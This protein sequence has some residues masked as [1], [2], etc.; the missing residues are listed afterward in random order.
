VEERA[1]ALTAPSGA[2]TRRK[3][4]AFVALVGGAVAMGA[5]PIFV[6][7]ADV[8]PYASAFWRTAL[9][10]PFLWAWARWEA[11]TVPAGAAPFDRAVL[12]SGLFFAGDLFFWHLSILSTTVAN[13]TFLATTSP[14]WVAL[15]AWL[16]FGE[17]IAGATGAGLA[18]CLLGGAA[19]V[20]QSYSFAPE[21]LWGD[22][23]GLITAVFFGSYLLAI[24]AGRVR[25][26]AAGLMFRSTLVTTVCLLVIALLF[27]D[28]VLPRSAG[29]AAALLA[30][31]LVSQVGGQGLLAVALGTLPAT[32]SSL[33]IF[34]EAIAAALFGW[35]ILHE[36]LGPLQWLGGLLILVGIW[37]GRP[38]AARPSLPEV[39][40]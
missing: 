6:R 30:L 9:A 34:I 15:A 12:L 7:L 32:F 40:P 25:H 8:G 18:L 13:A 16:L 2:D 11:R 27:D 5:S 33:V 35:A 37:V 21:R 17:R 31:A 38:R 20:G 4:L 19:L 24:R 1:G 36:A 3:A 23:Y 10:L 29:G 39:G 26:G 22:L 14:L 28:R